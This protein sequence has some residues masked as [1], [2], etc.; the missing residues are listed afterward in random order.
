MNDDYCVLLQDDHFLETICFQSLESICD[1]FRSPY[2][3]TD[4]LITTT[5]YT[6]ENRG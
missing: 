3:D 2:L 4:A 6:N 1:E 5:T